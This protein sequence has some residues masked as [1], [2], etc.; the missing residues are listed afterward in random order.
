MADALILDDSQAEEL[1]A[2]G[3]QRSSPPRTLSSEY[4]RR[5]GLTHYGCSPAFDIDVRER[6]VLPPDQ[7]KIGRCNLVQFVRVLVAAETGGGEQ[8][9]PDVEM[10]ASGNPMPGRYRGPG[11]SKPVPQKFK[12]PGDCAEEMR[13]AYGDANPWGFQVFDRLT[14]LDPDEA[15]SVF[16]SVLPR[17][18][19]L[20]EMVAHLEGLGELDNEQAESVRAQLLVGCGD[21]ATFSRETLEGSIQERADRMAGSQG[22]AKFDGRDRKLAAALGVQLPNDSALTPPVAPTQTP[23]QPGLDPAALE[24]MLKTAEENGRLKAELAARPPTPKVSRKGA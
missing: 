11:D 16:R 1:D 14:G 15:F 22:K 4:E 13:W 9:P 19:T 17:R 24:V 12:E 6:K 8:S 5:R 21:A 20:P 2:V 23:Q 3:F 7:G 10:D 18:M